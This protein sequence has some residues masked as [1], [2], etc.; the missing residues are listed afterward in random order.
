MD[1]MDSLNTFGFFPNFGGVIKRQLA[2]GFKICFFEL[3][4]DLF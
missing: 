3:N 1:C 2:S 4:K